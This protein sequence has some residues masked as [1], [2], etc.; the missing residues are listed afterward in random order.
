M[1]GVKTI[2]QG[3]GQGIAIK[4]TLKQDAHERN[5][6]DTLDSRQISLL[7][8]TFKANKRRRYRYQSVSFFVLKFSLD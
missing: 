2:P 5:K 1:K 7:G 8:D 3:M 6:N 4:N